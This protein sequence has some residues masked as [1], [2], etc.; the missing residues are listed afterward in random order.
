V[1][2]IGDGVV[3]VKTGQNR[4]ITINLDPKTRYVIDD[5]PARI[6]DFRTGSD[7]RIEYDV[8]DRRPVARI[9]NRVRRD[10]K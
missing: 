7:V 2:R 1:I 5:Q 8:R 9:I 4:E 3:V 10:N 6:T